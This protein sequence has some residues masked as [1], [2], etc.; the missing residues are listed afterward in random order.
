MKSHLDS[1]LSAEKNKASEII[2]KAHN[3]VSIMLLFFFSAFNTIQS[4]LLANKML[5]MSV[6]SDMILWIIYYLKSRSQFV[7]FQSKKSDTPYSNTVV[8]QGTVL[9]PFLFSLYTSNCCSSNESCT[10]VKFADDTVLI[11]LISDDDSNNHVDEINKFATYCKTIS[12]N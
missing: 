5:S 6:P 10:I 2:T 4:H 1:K 3:S 7:A 11:R 9:A 8:P 12:Y